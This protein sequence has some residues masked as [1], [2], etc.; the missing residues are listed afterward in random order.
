MAL[1]CKQRSVRQANSF[2]E[3][4]HTAN[5]LTES[6]RN[7]IIH[8]RFLHRSAWWLSSLRQQTHSNYRITLL[9]RWEPGKD[10][11]SERRETQI[12]LWM[13]SIAG[14]T[15]PLGLAVRSGCVKSH[16]IVFSCRG[17]T[18][19]TLKSALETNR[20]QNIFMPIS[21]GQRFIFAFFH[22][23]FAFSMLLTVYKYTFSKSVYLS[24]RFATLRL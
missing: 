14:L 24:V 11:D 15:G 17:A 13:G 5:L 22:N 16:V 23:S 18:P 19:G 9:P 4:T 8:V 6:P 10:L 20:E 12:R 7:S 21:C 2:P 1:L 3:V